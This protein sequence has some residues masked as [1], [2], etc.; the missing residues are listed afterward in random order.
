MS[1][2]C[3]LRII[4]PENELNRKRAAIP[5]N[6]N[7]SA[8][9]EKKFSPIAQICTGK[10]VAAASSRTRRIFKTM[11]N[12]VLQIDVGYTTSSTLGVHRG[13]SLAGCVHLVNRGVHSF[14]PKSFYELGAMAIS[15]VSRAGY[16]DRTGVLPPANL[17]FGRT[18]A[19]QKSPAEDR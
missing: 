4:I 19:M 6:R 9:I 12:M 18:A 7:K 1:G 13:S 5:G 15:A 16:G 8:D 10:P 14:F 2:Q 17:I 3:R 11:K